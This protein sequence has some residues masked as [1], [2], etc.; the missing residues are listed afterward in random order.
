LKLAESDIKKFQDGDW[1]SQGKEKVFDEEKVFD[2]LLEQRS[3][4][5]SDIV[6]LKHRWRW[7]PVAEKGKYREA[8]VLNWGL[9]GGVLNGC[10]L[11]VPTWKIFVREVASGRICENGKIRNGE[12]SI[13][14][15]LSTIVLPKRADFF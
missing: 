3:E 8:L 1:F 10:M 7:K 11:M 15:V 14:P 12:A 9:N 13:F 5:R 2:G 6:A 4:L